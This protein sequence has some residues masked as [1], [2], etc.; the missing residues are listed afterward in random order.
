MATSAVLAVAIGAP[1]ASAEALSSSPWWGVSSGAQ[2]TNLR[3]GVAQSEVQEI[4]VAE[5]TAFELLVNTGHEQKSVGLFATEPFSAAFEL[6]LPTAA[7]VQKALEAVYGEGNVVVTGGPGGTAPLI[8]TSVGEDADRAVATI[9]VSAPIGSAHAQVLSAGRT[10]GKIVVAA[11]NRGDAG[12]TGNVTVA[13]ELPAGLRAVAIEGVAGGTGR[14]ERGTV[15]CVLKT[16]TC[17]FSGSL[18]PYEEIEVRIAVVV[19]SGAKSGALNTAVVSGGGAST[20]SAT[21]PVE[22]NGSE[23]FGFD[24]WQQIPE[25]AGGSIDTQAGS[26]PFQLTSVVTLNSQTPDSQGRPR[27]FSLPK[28]IV[29]E[30]PAGLIGNPTPFTQCTDAQFAKAVEAEGQSINECPAQSAVGVATVTF[31][32]PNVEGLDT[33]TAPI[34]NMTPRTGEPA[35]FGFK[36]LGIFS[37]FLDASVRTGGD[38]GVTVTSSN[39]T[40]SAWTL[41]VKLAFWGVPGDP[42]HDGQRGWNCLW[43]LGA[44]PATNEVAPP[45]FLVMPTSCQAP[46]Q[47]TLRGDS[48]AASEKPS[49]E[50]EPTIYR[51]PEAIDGCNR[52]PFEPS[53]KVTPDGS[54]A[55]TPTGLN[56]DVHVPQNAVL[57][58]ESLAESAVKSITIAL[59]EGV[60]VNPAGGDGLQACS[61]S[62]VGYRPP[63]ASTPPEHLQ[64]SPTLPEPFCPNASKIGTVEIATPLLPAGQHLKGAVYL[65]TQNE[66]PFGS[67]I[68]MYLVAEDPISGTLVKLPGETHLTDT[69]Q[70][71]GTFANTPQLAF[72]DAEVHFFGGERAPLATPSHCGTYTTNAVFTPWS[73]NEA[74]P[75]QSHFDIT[76]G[77]NGGPCPG[78]TLP[79]SPSLAAATTNIEAGAFSALTTTMSRED[80]NQDLKAIQLH[81]P[82]GLSGLLS[83]VKLC[84]GQQADEGTCGPESLIGETIVSAGLGGDPVSVKGGKVYITGPYQG[85]PFGLSIVNPVKAGP[86]DL[87]RDTANP[88]NNA[89]CDCIVVRAR[90]E[91]D[92]HTTQ[93]T[94]TTDSTG[95]HAIPHIIDGIPVQIKHVNVII[96]RPG[97]TFNPTDCSPAAITGTI[98]SDEE[99][100]Q[101]VSVP[102]QVANCAILG[103]KPALTVS[104]S[105][106]TSK[107]AGAS[108]TVKLAYPKAP[109]G[110]QANLAAVKVNLPKQLPSRLTTLQK[111]CVA[112]TFDANAANCPSASIVGHAKVTTPLLPVPLEGP[113]YFVSHGG[114]AFPSLTIVLQGYGVTVDLVGSTFIKNGITSS[115]FKST[116]DVP[117]NTFQ[118]TL[119]EGKYSAL[120]ANAN[121]CKTKLNMPTAFTAQNGAVI[122]QNTTIR[123]AGCKA[124]KKAKRASRQKAI[125]AS[126]SALHG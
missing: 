32:N 56:V 11:E 8:V 106:H 92:P 91:V 76:S 84:P 82:P 113:A 10:D 75:S 90:V 17:T 51:L 83:S 78:A 96:N 86:F 46:F 73:G 60:A 120:A 74:A 54:A 93:L 41:G 71:V 123:V 42:R 38:Y 126:S 20:V 98:T 68:A 85:A 36:A 2:P 122:H 40:Q 95:A 4:T 89:A 61:E 79:F 50:A 33:A 3:S 48:W 62:Q 101:P 108:L 6:P 47:A 55:S 23:G 105:A 30:L 102:F 103:F 87:E 94:V 124:P 110:S 77:P 5:E 67:L 34:F 9:E 80:G 12:T 119:P 52:L 7:N 49:E 1:S 111:A 27:T 64:F 114:E 18:P 24:D 116:P 21:H 109:F 19:E 57:D 14:F 35:R 58:A 31:N 125:R 26:H 99:A 72:E 115:T 16:L 44:C 104:T 13:D 53:I 22:V 63:P 97:F 88:K 28:D 70:L 43:S 45:P 81:L 66:N 15:E 107:A 118:L 39:I 37:A 69:G 100:T 117:F 29:S 65:A 59:P 121:L 112:A 25:N